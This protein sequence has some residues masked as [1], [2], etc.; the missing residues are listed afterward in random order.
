MFICWFSKKKKLHSTRVYQTRI[1]CNFLFI[2]LFIIKGT[3]AWN[4][5]VLCCMVLEFTKLKY[6]IILFNRTNSNSAVPRWQ[7]W[8]GT[9]VSE[10][11]VLEKVV[12]CHLLPK[13]C[14]FAKNFQKM[15]YLAILASVLVYFSCTWNVEFFFFICEKYP[16]SFQSY[17]G[18]WDS[19]FKSQQKEN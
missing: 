15:W 9:R 5:R 12:L 8:W 16:N 18:T 11:Q 10:T 1:L 2:Y 19:F 17:H 13:Q 6:H 14:F 4:T 7:N 3:W